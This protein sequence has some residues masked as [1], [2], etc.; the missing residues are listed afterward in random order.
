MND[1]IKDTNNRNNTIYKIIL[2]L[3]ITLF[4]G[5]LP[6]GILSLL[7]DPSRPEFTSPAP[8][9]LQMYFILQRILFWVGTLVLPP[10]V[11]LLLVIAFRKGNTDENTSKVKSW[12]VMLIAVGIINIYFWSVLLLYGS[13]DVYVHSTAGENTIMTYLIGCPPLVC[14]FP[15][16]AIFLVGRPGRKKV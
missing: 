1:Q 8:E 3:A 9:P 4:C 16:L 5:Y 14:I 11:L 6:F 13:M 15:L 2:T 10:V 7:Y 12:I